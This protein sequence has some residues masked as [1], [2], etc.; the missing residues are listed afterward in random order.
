MGRVSSGLSDQREEMGLIRLCHWGPAVA[1]SVITVCTCM[2]ILDSLL[3]YWPTD[4]PGGLLNLAVLSLWAFLILYNYFSAMFVGPG[5]VPYGWK[6]EKPEDVQYLQYCN[7]CQ[8][9]KPP[10]S[11]HCRKCNRCVMKMDHHCPWINNCCGHYNH[12]YFTWFLLLAPLGCLHAS[13]IISLTIYSQLYH[14]VSSCSHWLSCRISF[15]MTKLQID[16]SAP[17]VGP[18]PFGVSAFA[19]SLFALGLAVGTTIAVG[20]LFCV[21]IKIILRNKTSIETWIEEKARDRINYYKLDEKFVFP[22]D[23]GSR[24]ANFKQVVTL[25]GMPRGNGVHWALHEGCDPYTLTVEQLKQKADKRARTVPYR[26]SEN[27]SGACCPITKGVRTLFG[28]PCTDEPRI[29]LTQGDVVLI[30]RATK[31]WFYGE[32]VADGEG[33]RERG[34]FPRRCAER[35]SLPDMESTENSTEG[36]K[37]S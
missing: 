9:Y 17:P 24:W 19:A 6:P 32:K 25:K 4:T 20:M 7:I 34:W 36:K 5:Y 35:I 26:A 33:E 18:V 14:R 27:Y 23:L 31:H 8:G 3:W 13:A 22:Y 12:A 21:Q 10:R 29:K 1:L 28:M 16:V 37:N 30:T 15:G 2:A 11:H